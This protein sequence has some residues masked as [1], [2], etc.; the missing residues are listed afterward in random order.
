MTE[1]E[2]VKV[3]ADRLRKRLPK[4]PKCDLCEPGNLEVEVKLKL[5]YSCEIVSYEGDSPETPNTVNFQTDLGIKEMREDG[6]WVPRVIIEAK[7]NSISTHDAITYSQKAEEHRMIHPY[8]RYG[9]MLGNRNDKPL[10][11]RLYRHGREF[12]FMMSF[13]EFEPTEEEMAAFVDLLAAEVNASRVM[14]KIIRE[15]RQQDRD[16]YHVF[17]RK[18]EV[19]KLG[20]E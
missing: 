9:V 4:L 5:P 3:I 11:G 7:V 18:L 17:H 12:D 15:S 6:H 13:R 19:V 8:L 2:W 1:N 16:H 14:E 10:P 20:E